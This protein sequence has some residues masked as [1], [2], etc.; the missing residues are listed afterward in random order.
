MFPRVQV[1]QGIMQGTRGMV[2]VMQVEM[3]A[4]SQSHHL[5]AKRKNSRPNTKKL[6]Q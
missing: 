2:Q 4:D 1:M 6:M 3:G 5:A